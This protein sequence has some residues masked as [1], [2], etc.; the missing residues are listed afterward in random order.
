MGDTVYPGRGSKSRATKF[1]AVWMGL[2]GLDLPVVVVR[3][4]D[5]TVPHNSDILHLKIVSGEVEFNAS[6]CL[7]S[8]I[9]VF[10]A[11]NSSRLGWRLS[12]LLS[13]WLSVR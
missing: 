10:G 13:L 7:T 6:C 1:R 11:S 8:C 2:L 5:T 9:R 3:E 4:L 12:L